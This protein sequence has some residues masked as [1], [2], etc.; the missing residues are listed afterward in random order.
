[1][2]SARLIERHS[3]HEDGAVGSGLTID[4]GRGGD[5]DLRGNLS[6]PMVAA[7]RLIRAKDGGLPDLRA[8]IA[9]EGV[10]AVVLLLCKHNIALLAARGQIRQ[11]QRLRIDDSI[12][13][14]DP[15]QAEFR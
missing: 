3:D 9:T 10:D 12:Y 11:I 2:V 1:M 15:D 7:G 6:T 14:E 8:R 13:L 5:A 4:D